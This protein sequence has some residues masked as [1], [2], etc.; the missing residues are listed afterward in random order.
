M[1]LL[2]LCLLLSLALPTQALPGADAAPLARAQVA[3]DKGRWQKAQSRLLPLAR[4]GNPVAQ[5][6]LARLLELPTPVRDLGQALHWYT[7][8]AE[9][10]A[11]AA[12]EAVGLAHYLGRGTA[13]DPAQAAQWF[14]RAGNA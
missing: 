8:L 2:L 6:A 11:P 4:K 9:Q 13:E 1:R 10:G 7:Q 3:I 5:W 12:M 14:R